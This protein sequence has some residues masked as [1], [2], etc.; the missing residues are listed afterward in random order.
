MKV[1]KAPI[2]DPFSVSQNCQS[3]QSFLIWSILNNLS[4]IFDAAVCFK[5]L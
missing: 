1:K 2:I 4:L 3:L 5:L